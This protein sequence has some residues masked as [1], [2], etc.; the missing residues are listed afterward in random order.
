VLT[1]NASFTLTVLVPPAGT[2]LV[3]LSPASNIN[4]MVTDG[5]PFAG[6]G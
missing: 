4:A 3:N 6:S 1:G 5:L 2:S